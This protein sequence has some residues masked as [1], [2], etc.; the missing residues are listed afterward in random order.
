MIDTAIHPVAL[1]VLR[2]SLFLGPLFLVLILLR[3]PNPEPRHH[4]AALFSMFYAFPLAFIGHVCA[5]ALGAWSY[6][7]DALKVLGFPA[8]IWF[9][10]SL[11]WGPVIFLA[12]PRLNPWYPTVAVIGINA[13]LMP[14]LDPFLKLG[15]GW[16]YAVIVIFAVAHLPALFLAQWTAK[17][18]KLPLRTFLLA[19]AYGVFAFFTLPTV[20]MHAMG[21][22]WQPL[23]E[24][25]VPELILALVALGAC[26]TVG[27]TAV[28]MFA[29]HGGGTPI[30]LDP[31]KRL[32][33]TGIYAYL[34]NPMQTCTAL[35]WIVMGIA[36]R[37]P[38]VGLSAVMAVLFVL[39][40]VR[41]HHRQDLEVRFP[42]GWAEYRSNV[43]EWFPRWRPW[44]RDPADLTIDRTRPLHR[45]VG[46]RLL[47]SQPVGLKIVVKDSP[48]QYRSPD[49]MV[50]YD[51]SLGLIKA[52]EHINLF[53][54]L[55]AASILLIA[56]TMRFAARGFRSSRGI[57]DA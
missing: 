11:L 41:W 24:R 18:V 4:L 15:P 31:T 28:Q 52:L 3:R 57:S 20:V 16:F 23:V 9:G 37:N 25:S 51:G 26:F 21:G 10:G 6:R 55:I 42:D 48:T 54:A 19:I 38:W 13:V 7:G 27:F 39:G 1:F 47:A 17:D 44:V 35:A 33:R 49:E 29:I 50:S 43:P 45:W 8:D 40:M 46:S 22:T 2:Q 34:R 36:L 5:I 12:F 30:P 14:A 53:W 56:L 32:V